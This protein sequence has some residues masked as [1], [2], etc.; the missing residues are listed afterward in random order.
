MATQPESAKRANPEVEQLLKWKN[1]GTQLYLKLSDGTI[2]VGRLSWST[3]YNIM[4]ATD[5]VEYLV[6][7]GSIL[8]YRQAQDGE[9]TE[10]V[11]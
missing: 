4:L 7:K 5:S 2:L 6:P 10:E 8:F 9:K 1:Q 11:Q 3:S